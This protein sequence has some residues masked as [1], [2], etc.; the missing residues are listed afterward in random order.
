MENG[1][2]LNRQTGVI[3]IV[4][5][6]AVFHV[7]EGRT[8]GPVKMGMIIHNQFRSREALNMPPDRRIF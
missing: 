7:A 1:Q 2:W 4:S 6:K 5:A 3:L 8:N